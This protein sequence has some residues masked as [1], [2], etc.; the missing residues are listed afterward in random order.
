MLAESVWARMFEMPQIAIVMGCLV[1]VVGVIALAWYHAQKVRSDHELKR[2]LVDRGMS[3]EEI[4]RI[5]AASARDDSDE[6]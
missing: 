6:I 4:E 3:A 2:T 1:P 5:I